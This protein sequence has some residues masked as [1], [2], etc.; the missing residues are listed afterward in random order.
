MSYLEGVGEPQRT[1]EGF[2]CTGLLENRLTVLGD[3]ATPFFLQPGVYILY[4]TP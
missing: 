4:E 2:S 3:W 1:G